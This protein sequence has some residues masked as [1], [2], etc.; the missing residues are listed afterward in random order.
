VLRSEGLISRSRTESSV[1]LSWRGTVDDW[2]GAGCFRI[3]LSLDDSVIVPGASS[4]TA[5][6]EQ[7]MK[8][9]QRRYCHT[10]RADRCHTGA[11]DRVQHPCGD[12]RDH[13][14][15]CLNVNNL[16]GGT[17]RHAVR[18]SVAGCGA[19]RADATGN[20]LQ[21]PARHGQNERVIALNRKNALF[22]GSDEGAENWAMLASLVET[23]KLHD[24]NPEAYLSDVLTKLVNN[25]PNTRL[26][27]LTPW[28]WAAQHRRSS[29]LE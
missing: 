7:M 16:P 22:A 3:L 26:A 25:W 11:G 2:A 12:C 15:H 6:D 4:E 28:A 21:L 19:Q 29:L 10:W 27:E 5:L 20:E 23:C 1:M 14:G 13:A 17:Q 9:E 24:V 18:C 8:L